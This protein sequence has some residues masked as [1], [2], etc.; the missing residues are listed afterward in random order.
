MKIGTGAVRRLEK[1]VLREASSVSGK[2]KD[3]VE[4]L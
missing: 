4:N 3:Y 1:G 2:Q